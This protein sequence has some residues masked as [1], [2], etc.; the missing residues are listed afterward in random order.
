[1]MIRVTCSLL[2]ML[3]SGAMGDDA[4]PL[5]PSPFLPPLPRLS[6][7][8]CQNP[9]Q[10]LHS[11]PEVASLVQEICLATSLAAAAAC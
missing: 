1:M 3:S 4:M 5:A 7:G 2:L 10:W 8:I 9:D 6:D 11:R